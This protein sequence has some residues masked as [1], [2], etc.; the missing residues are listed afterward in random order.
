MLDQNF[1]KGR[2]FD[3]IQLKASLSDRRGNLV[4]T[5]GEPISSQS[6]LRR[7]DKEG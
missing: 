3:N 4:S 7:E 2:V 6:W 1:A 5:N